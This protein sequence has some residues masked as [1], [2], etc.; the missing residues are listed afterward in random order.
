MILDLYDPLKTILASG[1]GVAIKA[2]DRENLNYEELH[3]VVQFFGSQLNYLG[4]HPGQTIGLV[5]PNGPE[6]ATVFLSIANFAT[7]APLN[8]SYTQEEFYFYLN[9]LSARLLLVLENEDTPARSA[10]ERLSIPVLEIRPLQKAGE[11]V[12]VDKNGIVP[13]KPQVLRNKK[14]DV[15][16]VLH[17]S[18]TTS[19]PKIV[20]LTANNL[21]TSARNVA[22][23]LS[24]NER[25]ICLNIMPLFHIHGL[26]GA[27]LSSFYSGGC[28]ICTQGFNILRFFRWLKK[29]Q[30]TWYTAV[31]TMHQ[32]ILDR[33]KRN[34]DIV[35]MNTLRFV[36]SS[37]A[38]LPVPV[39]HALESVFNCAVIEAYGMTEATHQMT[40]NPLPPALRK[41]GSVG[42]AAGSEITIMDGSGKFLEANQLGEIMIRGSNVTLGYRNNPEANLASFKERWFRTGDQ[43]KIDS[44]GYLTIDGRLK[45]I[46]NKGGEK[47]SPRE[48]DEVLMQH[49]AVKQAVCFAIPHPKLG[50]D[51]GAIA[52]IREDMNTSVD[53]ILRFADTKLVSFKV[54]STLKIVK[55]I[56]KGVTGKIQRVGLAKRL[57]LTQ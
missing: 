6:A 25:D 52:Q 8:P 26:V 48:V 57:G 41:P 1:T 17:T 33:A 18:G 16:L 7:A 15:A 54:P 23:S 40:S 50:E 28:V 3:E 39:F 47:I 45:E 11:F 4:V 53:D 44:E 55:E 13:T 2:I 51:V 31:P 5:L 30:P 49:P 20:P 19:R 32:A 35:R 29:F 43:G 42:V 12:L 34:K 56:P 22:E 27:V 24:L 14:D 9:D 36:R 38:S 10:A 21:S 37:S 46:I